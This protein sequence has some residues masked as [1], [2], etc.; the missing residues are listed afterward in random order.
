MGKPESVVKRGLR[1]AG[2][3]DLGLPP[4]I[5]WAGSPSETESSVGAMRAGYSWRA[6]RKELTE[7]ATNRKATATETPISQCATSRVHERNARFNQAKAM[8]ANSAP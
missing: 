3:S 1:S 7:K 4:D 2:A 8:M 5:R 6:R